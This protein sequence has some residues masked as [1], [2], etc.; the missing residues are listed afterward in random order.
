VT[1][2]MEEGMIVHPVRRQMTTVGHQEASYTL[3]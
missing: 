3:P 1:Q 2:H